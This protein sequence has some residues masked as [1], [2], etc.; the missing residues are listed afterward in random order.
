[1]AV[2]I[3]RVMLLLYIVRGQW[4]FIARVSS[5]FLRKAKS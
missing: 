5:V 1:M 2:L 3:G 4:M